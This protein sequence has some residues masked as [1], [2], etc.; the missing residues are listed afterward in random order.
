MKQTI[1]RSAFHDAFRNYGRLDNFSYAARD[2]LFDHF[3]EIESGM[4]QDE[5]IELDVIAI[6][7][8]YNEELISDVLKNYNLESL[9]ELKDEKLVLWHDDN[10]VLFLAY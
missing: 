1:N 2:A 6:C 4:G 9:E 10:N 3:E 8:E 5:E 7:C